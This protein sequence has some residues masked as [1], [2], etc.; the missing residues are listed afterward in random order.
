MSGYETGKHDPKSD[1]LA[2]IAQICG[3]TVD[4]LLGREKLNE[5][6]DVLYISRPS[7]DLK[8]DEIRRFLHETIDQL[9]DDN[10][11]FF[12]DFSLRIKR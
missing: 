11:L 1:M 6:T 5:Q 3:V 12:K 10:L 7:G 9:D 4:Y 2:K 8:V